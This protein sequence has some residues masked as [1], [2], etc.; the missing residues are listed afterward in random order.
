MLVL[1]DGVNY[2]LEVYF[3][4]ILGAI[5]L[6]TLTIIFARPDPS[7]LNDNTEYYLKEGVAT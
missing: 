3:W 2:L 1:L 6:V 4:L 5:L 7:E